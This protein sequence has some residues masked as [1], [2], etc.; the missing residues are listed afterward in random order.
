MITN[1]KYFYTN[2]IAV[3]KSLLNARQITLIFVAAVSLGFYL[4]ISQRTFRLGFPL[5]DAWIHQTYARNI[6]QSGEWAFIPG[7]PSAG[8]TAPLWSSL[9]AI[10]YWLGLGPY[11]WTYLLGWI[12]LS[13]LAMLGSYLFGVLCPERSSWKLGAGLFLIL[14]WHLVWA[15]GS[16]METLLFSLIV[17]I[18]ATWL[19][20]RWQRWMALGILI[21]LSIWVRPD[22]ITLLGPAFF[23]I[24]FGTASWRERIGAIIKL[25]TGFGLI[26]APYLLFNNLVNG[27][28]WPNTFY[29]KQAE[30]AIYQ[31][32][33]IINRFLS[34]TLLPQVGAGALLIPG[35]IYFVWVAYRR[36][37]LGALAMPI[38]ALGYLFLYSW[39]LPVTYQHGRYVIPMMP[40]YFVWGLSGISLIVKPIMPRLVYRVVGRAWTLSTV[41]VLIVFWI[42]GARSYGQDVAFIESEMVTTAQWVSTNTDSNALIAAHDIGALG[43]FGNRHLIDLA[44]LISPEVIPFIRNE[45]ELKAYLNSLDADYLVVFPG[46]YPSLVKD[47][48]PVYKSQGVFSPSQG[49]ENM[50]VYK[51]ISS[52]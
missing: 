1:R 41:G 33:P 24:L 14:E 49:G 28:W 45:T 23:V 6:A 12:T 11:T 27:A 37:S 8:S 40:V 31:Q 47:A 4:V 32:I 39:R 13:V 18:A 3:Y 19:V 35:F 7:Q 29:A 38:W 26:F 15:A 46:W 50:V 5:D 34:Q 16:G 51:W 9:L 17:L 22:G 20:A 43:F 48:Q 30:Y 42:L 10:G 52:Q 2:I 21:G 44:G 36:R 25:S